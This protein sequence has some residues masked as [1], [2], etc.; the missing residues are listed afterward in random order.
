MPLGTPIEHANDPTVDTTTEP[1]ALV[2]RMSALEFFTAAADALKTIPP[3]ATD[4]SLLARIAHLGIVP[5][6]SFDGSR[7]N[8]EQVAEMVAAVTAAREAIIAGVK[9]LGKMVNGWTIATD[10]MGVYGNYYFKRA[11]VTLGGLG[12]NPPEDAIYPVLTADAEGAP[13]QG[14]QR[15]VLHFDADQLPPVAAFWSVTMYDAEGFQAPNELDRFALG[16]R[17]PL[18]YNADG[19]LD[20]YLQHERPDDDLV[21]NW[22]PAPLGPLGVTMRLYAPKSDAL[23]G[24]WSPPPVRKS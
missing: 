24:H 21:P 2:N 7:F 4:F 11:V 18:T 9:T 1:L 14:E 15:Y 16:D 3:H 17:D 19:S 8:E 6:Q 22:L 23:D 10:T 12:A 20:F 5:G 13:L